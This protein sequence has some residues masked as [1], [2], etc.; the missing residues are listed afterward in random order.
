MSINIFEG[1]RR[2]SYLIYAATLAFGLFYAYKVEPFV[3]MTYSISTFGAAP[4]LTDESC[5][6]DEIARSVFVDLEL[7]QIR[8]CFR[9]NESQH[10]LRLIP[11]KMEGNVTRLD[12]KNS[13]NVAIYVQETVDEFSVPQKD[14]QRLKEIYSAAKWKEVLQTF[15]KLV[16]FLVG[17]LVLF[18]AI[19]WIVRGFLGIPRGQDKRTV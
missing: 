16:V 15:I 7:P 3:S 14:E 10:G 17:E 4:V 12:F 5:K 6:H 11:Y 13:S 2:I 1:A 19:G 18:A 8:I 9:A